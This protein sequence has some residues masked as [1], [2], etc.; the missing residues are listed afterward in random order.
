MEDLS[1]LLISHLLDVQVRALTDSR[2][3]HLG[4]AGGFVRFSGV[5]TLKRLPTII[6]TIVIWRPASLVG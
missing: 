6:G 1:L 3:G 5:V 4:E 2:L